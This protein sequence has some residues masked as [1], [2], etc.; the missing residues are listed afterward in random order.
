MTTGFLPNSNSD[1]AMSVS[2][3]A[4]SEP[5]RESVKI[6]VI[7][8]PQGVQHTIYTLYRLGFA[9]VTAWSPPQ[10]TAK[11]GE[12]ASLLVRQISIAQ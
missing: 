12:V 9:P 3:L 6:L 4:N 8:S 11:P 7:G 5:R 1:A 10:P 2:R